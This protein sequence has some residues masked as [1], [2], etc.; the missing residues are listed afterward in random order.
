MDVGQ[1][2]TATSA[3]K[4]ETARG[5][6]SD[7]N[8]S[9]SSRGQTFI[10]DEV[11]SIIARTA[12]EQVDGVH[13]LGEASLR[14]LISRLGRSHGVDAEVGMKEA[15]VDVEIVVE[16]GYPIRKVA[17]NIRSRVIDVVE[18]MVGRSVLEV[19][20]YVIDIHT[21]AV[22]SRRRRTLE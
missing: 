11:V 18:E 3:K 8:E 7:K 17:E 12:A 2:R 22:E 19:N 20:V 6:Q 16:F 4:S 13:R 9:A 21:P 10:D 15:A 14:T 1:N 5:D